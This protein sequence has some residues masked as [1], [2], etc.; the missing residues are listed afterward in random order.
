MATVG[1]GKAMRT[2]VPRRSHGEWEPAPDRK[3]PVAL[4]RAADSAR[5]PE[6]VAI[7]YERMLASEFAYFRGAA[8][9]MA[10]DLSATPVTGLTVQCCGDAHPANF[11]LFATPERRL[12]FSVTDFDETL[13]GPWEWDCKRVAAGLAIAAKEARLSEARARRV[14]F[15]VGEEYQR[16]A[17]EYASMSMLEVWYSTV[18]VREI[19]RLMRQSL[20]EDPRRVFAR[21]RRHHSLHAVGKLTEF[22][23]GRTRFRHVPPLLCRLDDDNEAR[24][25]VEAVLDD[26]RASLREERRH[27]LTRY[28]LVDVA[29]KVVGVGSV[30]THCWIALLRNRNSPDE[31]LVLQFKEA[32]TSVLEQYLGTSEYDH[33]GQRVVVGQRS[34]QAFPDI[35]LGWASAPSGR[36][37]YVRQLEDMKGSFD[38]LHMDALGLEA[39]AR[40]C[41][42]SLARAHARS[43]DSP[44]IASYL[45]SADVFDNALADF[46]MRYAAQNEHDYAA[47]QKAAKKGKIPLGSPDEPA[48]TLASL[49]RS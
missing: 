48:P 29:R 39:Y 16:R 49:P 27:L 13:C 7:R 24:E 41:G 22:E 32:S 19:A 46:A 40:L 44:T 31:P 23:D 21:A 18:D 28:E 38:I 17:V 42:W 37:Y 11:G 8:A 6:L 45:G 1:D 2:R 33:H 20:A 34:M 10:A 35:F 4:L 3:D 25:E 12:V 47:L 14:A 30:G 9:V 15:A 36:A 5:V 43:G 26:Y